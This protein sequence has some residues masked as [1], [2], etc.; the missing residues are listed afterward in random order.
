VAEPGNSLVVAD[1]S[2]IEMRIMAMYS[3]DP[4]LMNI[5]ENNIDVHAGTA[6][7]IL[8]KPPEEVTGEERTIYGK[9]PNFL[10]GYGGGPKRLVDATGGQ[11]SLDEARVVVDNYNAGYKGLTSWKANV[12]M[13]ARKQGYVETMYGRRRRVPGLSS[14]DFAE[15]SR[16]ERQAINAIVQGTASEICKDAMLTVSSALPYPKCRMLVQVHDE[17]VVSVPTDEVVEW[18]STIERA[19]GNGKVIM[20]VSLEVEAHF[21]Q[22]WAEAKG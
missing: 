20:G 15:K 13:K 2:Q 22:S 21:A 11:L 17:L 18:A 10:M 9:V 19:M 3:Q 4:E 16:S 6:S 1:Y 8:G 14:D 5:F 12:L 7:V